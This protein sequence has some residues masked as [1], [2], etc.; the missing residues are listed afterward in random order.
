MIVVARITDVG[1]TLIKLAVL[2]AKLILVPFGVPFDESY[3]NDFNFTKVLTGDATNKPPTIFGYTDGFNLASSGGIFSV[4][5]AKCGIH[6][7]FSVEGHLAF[8]IQ[9]GITEGYA[10]LVNNDAFTIDAVF[11]VTLLAQYDKPIKSFEKQLAT[12]PLSPLT[13]PGII[14]L[15]PQISVSGALDLVVSGKASLVIGGSLSID[16]GNAK[17]SLVK[18][19]DNAFDGFQTTFSPVAKV[20][21][22]LLALTLSHNE[23]EKRKTLIFHVP[24]PKGWSRLHGVCRAWSPNCTGGRSRCPKRQVQEVGRAR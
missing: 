17:L 23:A 11:G 18:K 5:C 1:E 7:D 4:Q 10:A 14:T 3:H 9:D 22:C 16:K 6:G 20:C 24:V 12:V 2:T 21:I 19:S 8:S 13:I 15:G